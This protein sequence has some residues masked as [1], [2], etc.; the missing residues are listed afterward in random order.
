MD[1][2]SYGLGLLERMQNMIRL[3]LKTF[4]DGT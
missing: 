3:T 1:T 4:D 2:E